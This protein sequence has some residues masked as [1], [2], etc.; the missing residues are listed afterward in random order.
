MRPPCSLLVL[1]VAAPPR[2]AAGTRRR[3][4][5][6]RPRRRR[7]RRRP[8]PRGDATRGRELVEQFECA[9]C[10]TVANVPAPAEGQAV[11]RLPPRHQ[12]RRACQRHARAAGALA[13]EGR[14]S[15]ATYRRSW[16]PAAAC[17]A[18]GSRGTC[19]TPTTCGPACS[20]R[21]RGCRSTDAA[22][23][24][25]RDVPLAGRRRRRR[26][27]TRRPGGRGRGA[28]A[29]ADWTSRAAACATA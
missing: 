6:R 7:A 17:D 8:P 18:R 9:R 10:H 27:P 14:S 23:G 12:R 1:A 16:P 19:C 4:E 13:A 3:S 20:R 11:R 15:W 28:R 5:Q 29:G 21:C 24:R 22:G 2:A 26:R 25:H